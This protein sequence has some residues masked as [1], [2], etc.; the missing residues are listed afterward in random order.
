MEDNREVSRQ[1]PDRYLLEPACALLN[2]DSFFETRRLDHEAKTHRHQRS[3][4][5]TYNFKKMHRVST[6]RMLTAESLTVAF[7]PGPETL[8]NQ[9]H[10]IIHQTFLALKTWTRKLQVYGKLT[11]QR[12][13]SWP[14]LMR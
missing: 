5:P 8:R 9:K 3:T 11:W 2:I 6:F 13:L 7:K 12:N 1:Q 14:W 10:Y 4:L